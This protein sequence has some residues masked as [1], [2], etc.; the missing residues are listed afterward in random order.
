MDNIK[1]YF[2]VGVVLLVVAIAGIVYPRPVPVVDN[3]RSI[4]DRVDEWMETRLG[5]IPG[6][7]IDSRIVTIGGVDI[8]YI[9]Q[10]ITAT[11]SALCSLRNP[12][13][14]TSTI[15]KLTIRRTSGFEAATTFDISTSTSA[16]GSST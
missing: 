8:G 14:S 5:A 10:P 1:N 6:T 4:T 12:F 16:F 13:S 7:T 2:V 11:S 15:D 3:V 9:G